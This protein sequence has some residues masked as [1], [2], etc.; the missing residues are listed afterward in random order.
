MRV[1][2]LHQRILG[3]FLRYYD[4]P[5]ALRSPSLMDER[6][7]ALR[8]DNLIAQEPVLEAVPRYA[9]DNATLEELVES[10]KPGSK[11]ASFAR[12]GLFKAPSPYVH[13]AAA[14]RASQKS[15]VVVKS[16]TGSG[17][18]EAFL[19]PTLFE[20]VAE[21]ERDSWQ[22]ASTKSNTW[23]LDPSAPFCSQRSGE[24]RP[25]AVRALILYPMNALVEDQIR[26]LR[27][28]IDSES[29]RAW[30]K[31]ELNGNKIYFG[32]YTGRTPV[33]G[34]MSRDTVLRSYR[35]ILQSLHGDRAALDTQIQEARKSGNTEETSRLLKAI[36]YFPSLDGGEMR[37]RSDMIDAPPDILITN[38]S[39][40]NTIL[41]RQREDRLFSAT[42]EWLSQ[43]E[44]RKFTLV[45]DE[46]HAYRGTAGT[47]VALLLRNVLARLGLHGGHPQLRI[48]ATSASLGKGDQESQFLEG[49]FDAP[50]DSFVSIDGTYAAEV[51]NRSG[52]AAHAAA[53]RTFAAAADNDES[54]KAALARTLGNDSGDLAESL[55]SLCAPDTVLD[56]I[57][58]VATELRPV[59]YSKLSP[60]LFPGLDDE[61]RVEATDGLVAAL[62]TLHDIGAG[63]KRPVLS[64]RLHLF[65][66]S[67]SGAWACSDPNCDAVEDQSDDLR[68]V[69]KFYAEPRLWCTCGS[70]VLQLLYCQTCGE[71]YLGGWIHKDQRTWV[72]ILSR[73]ISLKYSGRRTGVKL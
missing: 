8:S 22:A 3:D 70:K 1:S 5:F 25:A 21:A 11:F 26:R 39:M 42:R 27:E 14:F 34:D 71:Q 73:L 45:V 68:N 19:L 49:F 12:A 69:G 61:A 66:R 40:L 2:R 55:K 58:E 4:T 50:R 29:A 17:K 53:F 65:I 7:K 59:R 35:E 48:I 54:A 37:G 43:D 63:L 23:Y 60:A 51:P 52:L 31:G 10:I 13:Q 64:T 47:E 15:N 38:F 24:S 16:G 56:A 20:I 44:S 36:S 41:L 6:T 32:R 33:P 57:R 30:L 67:I 28:A 46:L 62:G 72:L 18:T 9:S